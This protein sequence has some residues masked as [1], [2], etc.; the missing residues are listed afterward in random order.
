MADQPQI[1]V[2]PHQVVVGPWPPGCPHCLRTRR[3]AAA[4]TERA[5]EIAVEVPEPR[6]P[7]FVADTVAEIAVVEP[8][9]SRFWI[10]D[11]AALTLS[12]HGFLP[13][14]RCPECSITDDDA[15]EAAVVT[16]TL[17]RKLSPE[18]SRVRALDVDE[19]DR[20]Y[21]DS[22]AGLIP[23]VTSY[24][25]HAFP[26]TEAVMAV[27]G[28]LTEPAG[29]GRTRDFASAWSIA[30]VESLER[31]GAYGPGRRT[32]VVA[33]YAE[34]AD[35]AIDPRSL[36]LYPEDRFRT[37]R[38]PYRE[39]T[40][41]AVTRWVWGYSFGAGRPVL[42]PETSV[43]YRM[44]RPDDVPFAQE[45]SNG[46][47]LGGCYEEAVLHGVLEIAERDA[48]LLAWYGAE[49]VPEL[50][51]DT[52]PDPRIPL[53]AE[54]IARQGYRVH[55]FDT[56]REHG[57]PSFWTMAEDMVGGGRPRAMSTGGSGLRPGEAILAALH[58]LCQT[59][60][61]VTLLAGDPQWTD[62]VRR[63]ADDP[64]EVRSMADHLLCA[65]NPETFDRYDFVL[66]DPVRRTWRQARRRWDWPVTLDIG[67]DLEEAVRR[68]DAA[69]MD[70]VA[71]DMTATEHAAGGFRCAKVIAPGAVPMTFGHS[72]RRVTGL[73]RLPRVRNPH[74]HP[75]P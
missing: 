42:V 35:D 21:V 36:G 69:G 27:P 40:E 53:V 37:P 71:V 14:S 57:I 63:L 66:A 13:D 16:R 70:V 4:S 59:V 25:H 33:G 34:V 52:V 7:T 41:D 3:V 46:C 20:T 65:A 67:A 18:S 28:V 26:F 24:T 68:F 51:L 73:A 48:C 10:V 50:D 49:A 31:L 39:F 22:R 43:Y 62:R 45:I 23:A 8:G 2:E 60:E 56:T 19:L 38:F 58:E 6:L 30:V 12:R 74:P 32:S 9:P 44:P 29:Y 64:A 5:A 11:K 61:Y 47:A 1:L 75:F 17:R 55:V 72:L 15:P 54:R